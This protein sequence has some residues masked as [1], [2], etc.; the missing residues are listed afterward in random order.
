MT[1]GALAQ[2]IRPLLQSCNTALSTPS[3]ENPLSLTASQPPNNST[4]KYMNK[5]NM[6]TYTQYLAMIVPLV[7]CTELPMFEGHPL[8]VTAQL[9]GL[10]GRT[11]R[12]APQR[13]LLRSH[14]HPLLRCQPP[15][16]QYKTP[17]EA[18]Q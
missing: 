8:A 3:E 1:Q 17:S 12:P 4:H 7:R 2:H 9:E 11:H 14:T 16:F 5:S 10:P 15:P 6:Q 18:G 13:C